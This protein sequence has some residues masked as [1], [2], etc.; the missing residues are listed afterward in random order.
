MNTLGSHD[1]SGRNVIIII[2]FLKVFGFQ[3][4]FGQSAGQGFCGT[5]DLTDY[6]G[7]KELLKNNFTLRRNTVDY[8][9]IQVFPVAQNDGEGR[10]TRLEMLRGICSLNKDFLEYG[11]QFYLKNP[12][13]DINNDD[14]FVHNQSNGY[15]MMRNNNVTGVFNIY[16]VKDP[17]STCGY[18]SPA[19]EAVA[20][21]KNCF[22]GGQ[23]AITHE[24][25]HYFGLPHTFR[26]W[27]ERKY[28]KDDVP[29]YLSVRGRDTMYVE[30]V[31]GR[32]C[33][34][35][36]D[37]FCDTP[38]D[39]LSDRWNCDGSGL[40]TKTYLDP[41]GAEFKVNGT[42]Y[43]SYSTDRCQS[44]FTPEQTDRMHQILQSR[45]S[46]RRY[47]YIPPPNVKGSAIHLSAP[48][49]LSDVDHDKVTLSW[50]ALAGAQ[51]YIV[52]VSILPGIIFDKYKQM[53][54][55]TTTETEIII[56]SNQLKPEQKYYWRVIPLNSFTFCVEP[57]DQKSF[58]PQIKS[59]THLLPDGD[60][61]RI[62]PNII[63][64]GQPEIRI[65]YTFTTPR[66]LQ[67]SMYNL[68]GQLMTQ[69]REKVIGDSESTL[70]T[71]N[72]QSG[73]YLIHISD[74]KNV[75]VQKLMVQ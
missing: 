63:R 30:T 38:P 57:S 14:Y 15:K 53:L 13:R 49:D 40:S 11:L 42:N 45:Y 6:I 23:H 46:S 71:G 59:S 31:D 24:M 55:F 35:S 74:G 32:N 37:N 60:K 4:A 27:E 8:Y 7:D 52:Q 29:Y 48:E 56:P 62:Y 54:Q 9:P 39:Y 5:P 44:E 2:I 68:N 10:L 3:F 41:N 1:F 12:I 36:G 34:F 67:L 72:L 25:G 22:I 28:D 47:K 66:Q 58:T 19:N 61:I 51:E 70:H 33:S 17:N 26:G 43:M 64:A 73:L 65:V 75:V 21:A 69:S 18:F 16:I 50:E 20:L